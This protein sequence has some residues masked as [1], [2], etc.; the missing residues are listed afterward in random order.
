MNGIP[1]QEI[2]VGA[3]GL[4]GIYRG[5]YKVT[6]SD[7]LTARPI[8]FSLT[9]SAGHVVK[10]QSKALVSFMGQQF[11]LI[12]IVRGERP[13]LNFGLG[14]DRL[15]GARLSYINPGVRLTI[16][17][18]IGDQYRVA[19]TKNLQAW[20]PEYLV[21]L[22]PAGTRLPYSLTSNWLVYGDEKY[23]YVSVGMTDMLP[24]ASFLEFAPTRIILDL[25]G[26][27]SNTNWIIQQLTAKEITNVY[28]T[29][30]GEDQFRITIELRHKQAWGYAVSYV[31]SNLVI[32][33]RRQPERLKLKALTI[34]LDAGHGG[35]NNGARGS[36]G[37]LEKDVNLA[38]VMHL[39]NILEDRGAKVIL[40][41]TADTN[42]TMNDRV[43]TVLA[44]GADIL[45]SVH[46][47]SIGVTSNPEDTKGVSTYY[48]YVCYRPLSLCILQEVLKMGLAPFGNVGSFNFSL[49]S[50]TELPNALV[51]MAFIS[52][53]EDEIKLLDD[54]FRKDIAKKIVNGID[55]FLDSCNE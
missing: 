54:D 29:M 50:P 17:G 7:T 3:N 11:P 5:R 18:K 52:N 32:K 36:T 21:N 10:R 27:V 34:A 13:Y 51:E 45:I 53:P 42:V 23:D 6:S 37:A 22:Q 31:G 8:E 43:R 39:K 16:T 33:I 2:P 40:T 30:V 46:S 28:Y 15:G 12:G 24:Y 26:A 55:D 41:R 25:F 9:D 4:G 38:T 14:E 1:M 20:I 44:S 19:L 35:D 48:K 49:N 47:N